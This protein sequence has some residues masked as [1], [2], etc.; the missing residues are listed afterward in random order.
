MEP[1]GAT[2]WPLILLMFAYAITGWLALF[3]LHTHLRRRRLGARTAR[4]AAAG[5]GDSWKSSR[6]SDY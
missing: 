3:A 2:P 6:A 1:A 4:E 5:Y